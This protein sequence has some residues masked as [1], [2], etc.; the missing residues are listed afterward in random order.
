[1]TAVALYCL[2]RFAILSGRD[3]SR[4]PAIFDRVAWFGFLGGR[5]APHADLIA[6][7]HSGHNPDSLPVKSYSHFSQ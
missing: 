3:N 4:V 2:F 5:G 6:I 7:P 1:M